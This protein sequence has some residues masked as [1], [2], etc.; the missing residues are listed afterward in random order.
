[1]DDSQYI[2][3]HLLLLFLFPLVPF[4][5]PFNCTVWV[6]AFKIFC[7]ATFFLSGSFCP[8][9]HIPFFCFSRH[10]FRLAAT[11]CSPPQ[12]VVEQSDS[13]LAAFSRLVPT[14]VRAKADEYSA[15]CST[16]S[17]EVAKVIELKQKEVADF[18]NDRSLPYA[19]EAKAQGVPDALWALIQEIQ[20][21]GGVDQLETSYESL[22][23]QGLSAAATLKALDE[24]LDDEE[25]TDQQ[26]RQ[27]L[28]TQ[29]NCAPSH[30]LN[31]NFRNS[32]ENYSNKL[33]V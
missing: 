19:V 15:S 3:N 20:V 33:K 5:T 29:W 1:M 22:T 10:L 17:Q 18:L 30:Q 16:L 28:Q 2:L 12:E 7:V 21:N 25:T 9:L 11:V 27:K 26:C 13:A 6:I 32:I 4:L 31:R 8:F 14:N 23:Q 24:R